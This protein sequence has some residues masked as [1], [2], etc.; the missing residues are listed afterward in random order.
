ML[1]FEYNKGS[2]VKVTKNSIKYHHYGVYMGRYSAG[3]GN[4]VF[5]FCKVKIANDELPGAIYFPRYKP[6]FHKLPEEFV[7]EGTR[8]YKLKIISSKIS[9]KLITVDED[10]YFQTAQKIGNWSYGEVIKEIIRLN[11]SK[12]HILH[13]SKMAGGYLAISSIKSSIFLLTKCTNGGNQFHV[14]IHVRGAVKR[15]LFFGLISRRDGMKSRES[16]G[17]GSFNRETPVQFY[18]DSLNFLFKELK[19]QNTLFKIVTNLN[20]N[21]SKIRLLESE[22]KKNNFN[23]SLVNGDQLECLREIVNS[24]IIIP[25]ISS[26]SMLAIFLSKAKYFWPKQNLYLCDNFMSIWGYEKYQ[27]NVGPTAINQIM[28]SKVKPNSTQTYRGMPFPPKDKFDTLSWLTKKDHSQ[29][30]DLIYYGVVP[31]N[32]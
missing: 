7:F 5:N 4:E 16:N 32:F 3:L 20:S 25:S 18:L 11:P 17:Y 12:Q 22:I 10:N 9:R 31:D 8:L 6:K 2:R 19:S 14:S 28:A 24:D 26:F 21:D 27:Q 15:K 23:F 13:K 29:F 30:S 1:R